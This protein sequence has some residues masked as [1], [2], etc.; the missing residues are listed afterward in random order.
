MF[1]A[2]V[3][4]LPRTT[5]PPLTVVSIVLR[6]VS[7]AFTPFTTAVKLAFTSEALAVLPAWKLFGSPVGAAEALADRKSAAIKTILGSAFIGLLL[8][9]CDSPS[10]RGARGSP[11]APRFRGSCCARRS[12][13][14]RR[15]RRSRRGRW[16]AEPARCPRARAGRYAPRSSRRPWERQYGTAG[17]TPD[18]AWKRAAN[19]PLRREVRR[20]SDFGEGAR[21]SSRARVSRQRR[22]TARPSA[23]WPRSRGQRI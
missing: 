22:Y 4:E 7:F 1:P 12:R 14:L 10:L 9:A 2:V 19:Q 6:R 3:V 16:C 15:C 23:R 5:L 8:C 20:A 13:P 18:T 17:Y 11:T 21:A